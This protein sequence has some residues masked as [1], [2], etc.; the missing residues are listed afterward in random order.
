MNGK[1]IPAPFAYRGF[2]LDVCR[3]YM[4][5]ENIRKLLDAARE[6]GLNV[7]HWHLTDDQGW[8]LEIRKYPQLA[9]KGSR[10]G[11]SCFGHVSPTENNSGF[12]TQQEIRDL[13]AYAG[14]RG[15]GILPEIEIPGHAAAL[16]AAV[17]GLACRREGGKPWK[18]RVE[19]TG[20]IFPSLVCAGKEE[21]LTFLQDVLDEVT[22]LFPYPA[23]H[24]GGDEALKI[25]WRRCPDCQRRM[26]ELGL[27]SE[28]A[29]QRWLVLRIGEYLAGKNRKTVVWNDVLAGGQLPPH[30]IVQHWMGYEEETRAFMQAGG[31]VICSDTA[32]YYL[33]YAYGSIDVR[34]IWRYPA[35]PEYARGLE[36]RLAGLECPLWTERIS[37]LS[38]AAWMLF[39][40]LTAA[41]VKMAGAG[42]TPWEEF[43]EE[44]RRKEAR[45][46]A[47]GLRGA[48]E[49]YWSLSEEDAEQDR[50]E[51]ERMNRTEET[52]PQIQ[53]EGKLMALDRAERLMKETGIPEGFARLAGDVMLAEIYG[54]P[55]PG[56][57]DGAGTLIRQLAQAADSR[58]WGRWAR[59][60]E[61]IWLSTMKCYARFIGEHRRSYGRDGFDRGEWTVRQA[62][63]RLFRIGELEYELCDEN[64][65][66]IG[67]HIPSDAV[68]EAER[69]NASLR[70]AR[71]FLAEYFPAYAKAPAVC[72]SWLLSPVL[73]E[74]LP[75]DSRI[76]RFQEAFDLLETDPEDDAALEWVFYVAQGQRAG[77]DL[78]MLPE[79]TSL[80][81][82]LKRMLLEG[83]KPG[84]AKGRLREPEPWKAVSGK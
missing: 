48:P 79:K 67:L 3:H 45:V 1:T 10:R 43:L 51:W 75:A 61:E 76:L 4:P 56:D 58:L 66:E 50:L 31:S 42:E 68:L 16:L 73:K 53:Q 14:E 37:N 62:E 41:S 21:T 82:G 59:L 7:M 25:R 13:V 63:A 65:P 36:D 69:L 22:E 54:E 47:L 30:F 24:I 81:R 70:D 34:K 23:V 52:V 60:P 44:V 57:R 8:R 39:P 71:A 33:D 19:V 49:K 35:V 46:E 2:M 72:E 32:S 6:L 9:E 28:D 74:V 64:G 15:I 78:R 12:Y 40:R 29:L 11:D 38:R 83:R 80:Q 18:D 27:A 84:S 17:P 26:R 55:D 77:L 20:G 5:P